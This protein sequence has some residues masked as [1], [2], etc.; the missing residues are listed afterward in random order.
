MIDKSARDK[1]DIPVR[2]RDGT[3]ECYAFWAFPCEAPVYE[4]KAKYWEDRCKGAESKLS[5]ESKELI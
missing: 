1:D 5:K 3:F 4:N 2:L